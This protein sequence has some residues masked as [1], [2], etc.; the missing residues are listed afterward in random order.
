MTINKE[1]TQ[2]WFVDV[3]RDGQFPPQTRHPGTR[4][5]PYTDGNLVEP[6]IDGADLMAEFH[7]QAEAVLS[8]PNP[9]QYELW[10]NQWRL[11]PVNLLGETGDAS[12]AHAL[13]L[14]LARAG[15]TV[16]YLG[17]GHMG[18]PKVSKDFGKKLTEAG[19]LGACDNRVPRLGSQHQKC[20][21]WR[22]PGNEWLAYL[23]SA[24]LNWARWD[25]SAHL[26]DDPDRHPTE[27]Q[28]PSHDVTVRVQG[29]ACHDIALTFV[30][31]WNDQANRQLTQ[32]PISST[33]P[34]TF[35][36][37]PVPPVG[38][39][40]VQM[41]R[42]YSLGTK[43]GYS[44]SDQGE[45]TVWAAYL[46]AIK[47]ARRY[48]YIED[49]YFYSFGNPRTIDRPGGKFSDSDIVY[50]LGEAIKR[51][52]DIILLVPSRK[53][54]P[55]AFLQI[56]ERRAAANYLRQVSAASDKHGRVLVCYLTADGPMDPVVHSK[57]MLVDDELSLIGSANICQRS[58]AHDT[59]AHLGIV[60]AENQFTRELRLA[61]WQE[62]IELSDAETILD[63]TV[64]FDAFY[65]KA[66][67]ASGRL[68][69]LSDEAG[70]RII[71]HDFVM[72]KFIDPY[73]G[74]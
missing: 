50:Q 51:G 48:I 5:Q 24:D 43:R 57:V 47:Q 22:N 64:G 67:S 30:E 10:L 73:R 59:E 65:D 25:T 60:D 49:Q 19:G 11:D 27:D 66:A 16:Y 18:T 35:L 32:P 71:F 54:N 23:G 2:K 31:R 4:V 28:G 74:P 56:Y 37:T 26:G 46:K 61:L 62:H 68:R 55:T 1:L 63:P 52:V 38:P 6:I 36:E 21:I 69:L 34:T 14:D 17:S 12:D 9:G 7:R 58:M 40:S 70:W 20:F 3:E 13:I 29:P 42:T 45:F 53:G 15:V 72:N 41:L 33:I 44:W 8:A 39:H